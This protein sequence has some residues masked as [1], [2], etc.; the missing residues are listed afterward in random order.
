MKKAI[1]VIALLLASAGMLDAQD[2]LDSNTLAV[3]D[4]RGLTS[5]VSLE[6][7]LNTKIPLGT[8][9]IIR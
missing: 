8:M 3:F 2:T 7:L 1:V 9:I 5:D 4:P 6:I